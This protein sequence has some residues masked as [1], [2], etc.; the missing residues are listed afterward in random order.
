MFKKLFYLIALFIPFFPVLAEADKSIMETNEVF[1]KS[2]LP[3]FFSGFWQAFKI[4]LPF[5]ILIILLKIG[6]TRLEK[7][8]KKWK[9]E[10][11]KKN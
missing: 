9:E 7:K 1:S 5:L 8:L 6:F 3:T 2:L 4:M 10:K 11:G